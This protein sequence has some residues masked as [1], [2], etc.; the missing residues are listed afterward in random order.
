M[1]VDDCMSECESHLSGFHFGLPA[2]TSPLYLPFK[3]NN[4]ERV[5]KQFTA[6]CTE[7]W[8]SQLF[9]IISWNH[10][11]IFLWISLNLKLKLEFEFGTFE[12]NLLR[13]SS[14]DLNWN[15]IKLGALEITFLNAKKTFHWYLLGNR[16]VKSLFGDITYTFIF[17]IVLSSTRHKGQ[18]FIQ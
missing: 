17:Q 7:I 4:Y 12:K 18:H 13:V 3:A 11:V 10:S 6:F 5:N 1:V 9:Y 15:K 14:H 16:M 8:V 2:V